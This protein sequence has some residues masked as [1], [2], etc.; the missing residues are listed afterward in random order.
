MKKL[1]AIFLSLSSISAFADTGVRVGVGASGLTGFDVVVGF[2][3]KS[4]DNYFLRHFGVRA[5][6]ASTDPLKSALDSAI[7]SVMRDGVSVGNGVKIDNGMLDAWHSSL[8][9]DFYPFAGAWHITGGYT[10]GDAKLS[11]D[12]FGEI[13]DAPSNRFY[14][15][16]AGD[17]YYYNGN[18]FGGA[19]EI[20]WKIYGPYLGTGFDIRLFCGFLLFLDAGVV[21]ADETAKLS[22]NIPHEQLYMYDKG[23]D[24]WNPVIIPALDNDVARATQEAND[25]LSDL[26]LFP[27][28]KIGFLY[29]F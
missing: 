11:A 20:D 23:S 7:D 26:K 29:H 19:A 17:H 22:L 3:N 1:I 10:W 13:A 27:M 5:D 9:L 6:F 16:L 28:L 25:K 4:L 21:F 15:N 14:F 8:L 12:I 2:Y 18:N 24:S